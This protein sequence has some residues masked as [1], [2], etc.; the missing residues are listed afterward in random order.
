[1]YYAGEA[2]GPGGGAGRAACEAGGGGL[3]A[4]LAGQGEGRGAAEAGA[5]SS[6]FSLSCVFARVCVYVHV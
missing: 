6:P 5:L 4:G 3:R 2:G 1:M